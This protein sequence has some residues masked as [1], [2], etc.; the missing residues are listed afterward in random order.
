MRSKNYF[1]IYDSLK[2]NAMKGREAISLEFFL[3]DKVHPDAYNKEEMFDFI[4]QTC[5]LFALRQLKTLDES[6]SIV[7]ENLRYIVGYYDEELVNKWREIITEFQ[8]IMA[9]RSKK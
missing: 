2:D 8:V 7:C 3:V 1:D 9:G 6:V 4:Q 5:E